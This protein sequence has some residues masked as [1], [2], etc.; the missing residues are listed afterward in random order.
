MSRIYVDNNYGVWDGMNDPDTRRFWAR[1]Q[2]ALVEKVCA[3]CGRTVRIKKDYDCCN[4]CAD[5]R[6]HGGW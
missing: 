3:D 2:R 1:T 4:S 6:E 5:R